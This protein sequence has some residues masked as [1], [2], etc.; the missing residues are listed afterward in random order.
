MYILIAIGAAAVIVLS[1]WINFWRKPNTESIVN[2]RPLP[3]QRTTPQPQTA[4]PVPINRPPSNPFQPQANPQTHSP[5]AA[6]DSQRDTDSP[7][8]M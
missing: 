4:P 7:D 6:Q 1:I 2:Y 5:Q 3:V 8:D